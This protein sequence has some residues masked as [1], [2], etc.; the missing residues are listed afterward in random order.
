MYRVNSNGLLL[1]N[2][3]TPYVI[4]GGKNL[5]VPGISASSTLGVP[6]VVIT[7]PT[8]S[9]LTVNW[10]S[11]SGATNYI[12][13]ASLA[14]NDG[15]P[16]TYS[17][18]YSGNLL[19][20][21]HTLLTPT[22]IYYYR[23][24]AQGTGFSDSNWGTNFAITYTT[25][26]VVILNKGGDNG[27]FGAGMGLHP[28]TTYVIDAANNPYSY[29]YLGGL[30]GSSTQPAL[31][32]N[33]GDVLLTAGISIEGGSYVRVSGAGS[34]KT[35]T[36]GIKTIGPNP[37][38]ISSNAYGIFGLPNNIK[39]EFL[40][41]TNK[42]YT[43]WIKNESDYGIT[44][45]DFGA[46]FWYPAKIRNIEIS[47]CKGY[48]LGQD[49]NYIGSSRPYGGRPRVVDHSSTSQAINPVIGSSVVMTVSSAKTAAY[50]HTDL[51]ANFNMIYF[52]PTGQTLPNV[53]F[54]GKITDYN[55][56][57]GQITVQIVE[58]A[59]SGTSNSWDV[60]LDPRPTGLADI[61]IHHCIVDGAGR[62]GIQWGGVDEGINR[63]DHNTIL[64]TGY[65]ENEA[66]GAGIAT[67]SAARNVE[68]D[69]NYIDGTYRQAW[70]NYSFG[71]IY[72]HDNTTLNTGKILPKDGVKSI[73][74]LNSNG[75]N[76][77]SSI[78]TFDKWVQP[79]G[80]QWKFRYFSDT[81][82]DVRFEVSALVPTPTTTPQQE[83]AA[84]SQTAI[85][86]RAGTSADPYIGFGSPI[87]ISASDCTFEDTVRL[88]YTQT[89][90]F[91]NPYDGAYDIAIYG[92]P[93]GRQQFRIQNN[94]LGSNT[95]I[96]NK[97]I[98]MVASYQSYATSGNSICNNTFLGNP[99]TNSN[100]Q[101]DPAA[102]VSWSTVC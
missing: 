76:I 23:V 77:S 50:D 71:D 17:Q 9:S 60:Y 41:A 31:V 39:A 69:H 19:N 46:S 37:N 15:E 4:A 73:L 34:G 84:A 38:D 49:A 18:I 96:N 57:T 102:I 1:S 91:L 58:T 95:D 97:A 100:V 40:Y 29:V 55:N 66:Q 28:N 64:R 74:Q 79:A 8:S 22:T 59:G 45:A 36:Y 65:E 33:K 83:L 24:K 47:H 68:I 78:R 62:Q 35:D 2:G 88:P 101:K 13:E 99:L 80:S 87:P 21:T 48:N 26:P 56:L 6:V 72:F 63:I 67:G 89:S 25:G 54:R 93:A 3:S 90:I 82:T 12:V 30:S 94:T 11:V 42:G 10:G 5:R 16:T 27:I 44:N 52:V 51:R 85:G 98:Y 53:F 7:N 32:V 61:R 20:F 14:N 75:V 86:A 81:S 92:D 43:L 70:Y